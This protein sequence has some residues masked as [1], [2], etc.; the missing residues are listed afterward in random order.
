MTFF[1]FV[2]NIGVPALLIALLVGGIFGVAL[3]FGLVART[4]G[5]LRMV[6]SMNRWVSTRRALRPLEIPRHVEAQS[7]GAKLILGVFLL[8]GGTY[9]LF[10]LLAHLELPR[11][12]SVLAVDLKRWFL[13]STVLHTVKWFLIAGSVLAVA[14][15]GLLLFFPTALGRIEARTN[16]WYSTRKMIPP[17]GDS[18]KLGLERLVENHP[19]AAGWIIGI[20]CFLVATAMAVLLLAR[21]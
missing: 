18:M 20:C 12:A 16:R 3:G 19:R 17:A 7:K 4:P 15:G 14:V 2:A 6:G 21:N 8:A 1:W 5:T 11:L 9:S 13:V 10:F